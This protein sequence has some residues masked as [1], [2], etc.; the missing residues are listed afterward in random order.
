MSSN[1]FLLEPLISLLNNQMKE[2]VEIE[3]NGLIA[4]EKV[5][6]LIVTMSLLSNFQSFSNLKHLLIIVREIL[7]FSIEY[8]PIQ[9]VTP[10]IVKLI[11]N[12]P[13]QSQD[14]AEIANEILLIFLKRNQ[15]T[16]FNC[17]SD[18]ST[19]F[20]LYNFLISMSKMQ[21]SFFIGQV[22]FKI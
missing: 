12:Q 13:A 2:V 21:S 8:E 15:Q 11:A 7:H 1:S 17:F 19:L 10:N 20:S 6:S 5:S 3:S 16:V 4:I 22:K 9:A 14:I 18:I